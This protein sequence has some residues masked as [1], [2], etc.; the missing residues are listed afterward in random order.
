MA[1]LCS[2]GGQPITA[3]ALDSVRTGRPLLLIPVG[4]HPQVAVGKGPPACD[5]ASAAGHEVRVGGRHQLVRNWFAFR[6]AAQTSAT[7]RCDR[8]VSLLES[9]L[10][11][12]Y[13]NICE[14]GARHQLV[15][16]WFAFRAASPESAQNRWKEP[17]HLLQS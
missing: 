4:S 3:A 16:N 6:T 7:Y 11:E 13:A 17:L 14:I 1:H 9:Q 15:S 12:C 5:Q 10:D 8:P 2:P